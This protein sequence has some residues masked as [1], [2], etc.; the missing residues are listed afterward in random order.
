MTET[1]T[2]N[3]ANPALRKSLIA[4]L[5][6]VTLL[7]LAA[8]LA[9]FTVSAF[10]HGSLTLTHAGLIVAVLVAIAGVVILCMKLWP[11]TGPEPIGP[12]AKKSRDMMFVLIALSLVAG[13]AFA[14]ME[15]PENNFL[16]SNGPIGSTTAIAVLLGW[17]VVMPIVTLMWWRTIDEHEADAYRAGSMIA[18]HFYMFLVPS[19]WIAARAGWVPSQDPMIVF[20]I[21]CVVWSAAWFYK[22]FN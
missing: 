5:G 17:L 22:K 19:W 18:G 7:S 16:F 21:V 6:G 2:E 11:N 10:E 3:E 8:F 13:V 14:V 20:L 1:E 15:G 9:G 4:G 12:S